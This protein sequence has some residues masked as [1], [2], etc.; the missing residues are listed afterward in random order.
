MKK[1]KRVVICTA[2]VPFVSGGA[3]LH[4]EALNRELLKR[5]FNSTIV[6]VPFKWYPKVEIMKHAFAWRLLDL[7][8]SNGMKID[9][10]IPTKFPSYGIK[11]EN[12]VTWLIH[13]FRQI[14][15]LYGT[16]YSD[17]TNDPEDIEI[18]D[19]IIRFDNRTLSESKKIF[20]NAQNTADRLK[21]YNG[22]QGQ[23][24]YH[25]PQHVG[26]Y[27]CGEY[28]K[29]VLS[30]GRLDSIKRVDVLINAMKYVKSDIQCLIG[31]IGPDKEK[32]EK[33]VYKN[34]L[35]HR[36]KFLGFVDD[37]DLIDLY[38]NCLAVYYAPFDEDYGYVTLEAFLSKKP[39][40][41]TYDAG[42][43]L[44]FVEDE[45]NGF[46]TEGNPKE[47]AYKIDYLVGHKSICMEYGHNGWKKASP[48]SW[49]VVIDKLTS[50]I[51]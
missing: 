33:M 4:V 13:Q 24:L 32:L 34:K 14:Y 30:I 25:P 17:F 18:R 42:G 9:L 7:S 1:N 28:G 47:I 48:I 35:E 19:M 21:K 16:Q 11:H 10:V 27:Y 39:V 5:G 2:Q 38:A 45:V 50:T 51:R 26:N 23:A 12:K 8:E 37:K 20:T 49:D 15:D 44:E 43:V 41:T 29:Y 22:I 46:V 31:G 36:V 6:R 3:E 40:I